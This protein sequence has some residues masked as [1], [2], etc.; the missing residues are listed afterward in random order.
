MKS[1]KSL[2]LLFCCAFALFCVVFF[3]LSNSET[4]TASAQVL[5]GCP[6]QEPETVGWPR[7]P[8]TA[9]TVKYYIDTTFNLTQRSQIESAF[10]KWT[11]A[12]QATCLKINFVPATNGLAANITVQLTEKGGTHTELDASNPQRIL[13]EA[14][15]FFDSND[16]DPQQPGYSTAFLKGMLHEIGHTMGLNDTSSSN[17][18]G[19]SVMNRRSGINDQ[20]NSNPTEVQPCD[21]QS[22]NQNP[23]CL[24]TPTPSPTPSPTPYQPPCPN[25]IGPKPYLWCTWDRFF[26]EWQCGGYCAR[27][28]LTNEKDT[29]EETEEPTEDPPTPDLMCVDCECTSPILIDISGNGF[30]LTDGA[31]GV[32]FD[33]NGDG[34]LEHFAWTAA[35]SDDAW[36][37]LDRNGDGQ[38][39]SGA[40]M[41][42]N[43]TPQASSTTPNGFLA[44]AEFDKPPRGGNGNGEIERGDAI[45]SHLRLWQDVNHNG[46]SEAQELR[47]LESLGVVRIDLDY[48]ESHRHDEHGNWFRYRAKVKDEHGAQ[49][50]R[51]AWDVYLRR[52]P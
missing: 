36:L 29:K 30:A 26:C 51:W 8:N 17:P 40:E 42:G 6:T 43:Y 5:T 48:K 9:T 39:S 50:G 10:N 22:V 38:I 21:I 4:Q 18:D 23:R 35:T 47:T 33:L 12:S 20:G 41:F 49:V 52:A 16:F 31:G 28:P 44:L 34:Q 24:A 46:M 3:L 19:R 27:R 25:P 15:T 2:Y 1:S 7:T 13:T 14:N 32:N 45:F 11:A 37:V